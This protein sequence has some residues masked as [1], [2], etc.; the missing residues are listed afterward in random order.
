MGM[1]P[2]NAKDSN[3]R[4]MGVRVAPTS[5]LTWLRNWA[6]R[7]RLVSSTRACSRS[8]ASSSRSY[9]MASVSARRW[10]SVSSSDSGWRRRVSEKRRTRVSVVE[11]RNSVV[12]C[13]SR[14]RSAARRRGRPGSD[15]ALRTSMAMATLRS[16]SWRSRSMK[17]S[18][19]SGGRLSTQ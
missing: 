14:E 15:L 12:S 17:A 8:S 4:V 18:S 9:S 19:S 7:V 11:S 6:A 1:P 3:T 10:S 5:S 13:T 2:L 16:R